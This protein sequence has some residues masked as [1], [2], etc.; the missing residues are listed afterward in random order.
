GAGDTEDRVGDRAAGE[1]HI[2]QALLR[3]FRPLLDRQ[4]NFLGLAVPEPDATV[5]VTDDDER[6]EREP[7]TTLD[8]LGDAVDGDD[9]RLAQTAWVGRRVA[10]VVCVREPSH[11][12]S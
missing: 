8:D 3:L 7:A 1:G 9:P 5:A 4:R 6:S 11:Q 2:E 12:N 10:L